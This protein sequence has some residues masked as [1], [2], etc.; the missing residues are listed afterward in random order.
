MGDED[1]QVVEIAL[2]CE[3]LEVIRRR[4]EVTLTVIAPGSSKKLFHVWMTAL[5]LSYHCGDEAKMR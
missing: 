4:L 1:L 5:L 3:N 2:T